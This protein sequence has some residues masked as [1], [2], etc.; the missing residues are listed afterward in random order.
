MATTS[1]FPTALTLLVTVG[2][3]R[4]LSGKYRPSSSSPASITQDAHGDADESAL[5]EKEADTGDEGP[6]E[7]DFSYYFYCHY[8]DD[9]IGTA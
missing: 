6:W 3:C 2:A 4:A 7:A 9:D 8:Y 5:E 1:V